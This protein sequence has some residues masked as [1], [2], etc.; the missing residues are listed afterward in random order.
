MFAVNQHW[1]VLLVSGLVLGLG[2]AAVG[3]AIAQNPAE[4][5]QQLVN[6]TPAS[7]LLTG[8]RAGAYAY[9][10]LE[11]PGDL[12]VVTIELEFAPADPVT[13]LGV[14]MNVYGPN[15]YLIGQTSEEDPSS[16]D[17]VLTVRYSDGNQATWLVQIYNYIP[18]HTVS[19][20][21]TAK[22]LP[23]TATAAATATP[24]P[25]PEPQ[26]PAPVDTAVQGSLTGQQAGAFHFYEFSYPGDG[27]E[28]EVNMRY[29]PDNDVIARGV[30]FVVYGPSGEVARGAGTG[31][32]TERR[33]VFASDVPGTYLIQVYNYISGLTI[34]YDIERT[35]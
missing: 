14:G 3:S 10:T 29:A 19:Y 35:P 1:R 18:N 21:V 22:G 20:A 8:D 30:G 9:Y 2:L 6:E 25:G 12:R 33:S 34:Q 15:G 11:Y 28:V 24:Q 31:R 4:V 26:P 5:H 32:P 13:R 7:G 17:E 16:E 27:S 23:E